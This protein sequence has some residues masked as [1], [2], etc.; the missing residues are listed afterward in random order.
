MRY[1]ASVCPSAIRGRVDRDVAVMASY[2]ASA[3]LGLLLLSASAQAGVE[4]TQDPATGLETWQ[5][6]G[7]GAS[8]VFNQRLPDQTRAFYLG[9]GLPPEATEAVAQAC[10]FQ[11]VVRNSDEAATAV[12]MD[13]IRWRVIPTKGE[14]Q[15]LRLD[16]EWQQQWQQQAIAQPVRIAFRWSLFPTRQSFQPGDWNMGMV[17]FGLPHGT[18]FDLEL[19]WIQDGQQ[20]ARIDGM[21]CADDRQQ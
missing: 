12:D 11:V 7:N 20:Q 5:W 2:P 9:R 1:T 6:I 13:L 15:G 8:F 14:V 18:Q 19:E 4:H 3:A 21:R 17:T 10:V 16:T